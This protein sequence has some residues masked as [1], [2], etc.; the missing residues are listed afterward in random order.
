[1]LIYD[2]VFG[3][4]TTLISLFSFCSPIPSM[5]NDLSQTKILPMLVPV[6]AMKEF[7]MKT[8]L[9]NKA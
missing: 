1:M 9:V 2:P 3:G 8:V 5:I 4:R 6:T 7:G